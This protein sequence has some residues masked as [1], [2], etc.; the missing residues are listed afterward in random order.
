MVPCVTL[1]RPLLRLLNSLQHRVPR[2]LQVN[3]SAAQNL[4]LG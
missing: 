4:A 3:K 1:V 2:H